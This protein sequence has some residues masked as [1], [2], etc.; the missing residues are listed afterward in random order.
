M[1]ENKIE[2]S[3][4]LSPEDYK[5]MSEIKTIK[6][7][8]MSYI[9]PQVLVDTLRTI[10]NDSKVVSFRSSRAEKFIN[11]NKPLFSVEVDRSQC[12]ELYPTEQFSTEKQEAEYFTN[13]IHEEV[14]NRFTTFL[15]E[16]IS[17]ESDLT[18]FL[19][20]QEIFKGISNENIEN[21]AGMLTSIFG[22]RMDNEDM[23]KLAFEF[24]I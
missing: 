24:L 16:S 19:N 18:E 2:T 8:I 14:I 9:D 5:L 20:K 17:D 10:I 3:S 21:T 22:I 23:S 13:V 7:H 12:I 15:V 6:K 11:I 1:E 4:L